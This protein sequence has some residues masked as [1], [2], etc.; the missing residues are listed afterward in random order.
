MKTSIALAALLVAGAVSA[1]ALASDSSFDND[2]YVT[3][4]QQKGVN[5]I[6]VYEGAPGEVRAVVQT[7][8]G[9]QI[10]QY[11][12]EETLAPTTRSVGTF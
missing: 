11:F 12:D 4:L 5:A 10:F 8:D 9:R 2:W 1:P 6:E 7:A 3:Q